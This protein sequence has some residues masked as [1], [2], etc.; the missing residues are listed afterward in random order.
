MQSE[1]ECEREVR[2]ATAQRLGEAWATI[3]QLTGALRALVERI[4]SLN[5]TAGCKCVGSIGPVGVG[6]ALATELE[7][8][9]A[10]LAKPN[11]D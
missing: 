10:A 8:T 11:T 3:D 5:A 7:N 6:V 1:L 2:L 9:R 4:D